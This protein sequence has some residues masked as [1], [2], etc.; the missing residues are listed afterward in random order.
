M[1]KF[2]IALLTVAALAVGAVS[3]EVGD[4]KTGKACRDGSACCCCSK[5]CPK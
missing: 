3:G 5:S 2:W 1:R 4:G